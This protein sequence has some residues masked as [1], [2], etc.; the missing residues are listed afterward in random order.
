[1]SLLD[2]DNLIEIN[3]YYKYIPVGNS[4]KLIVMEE[5]RGREQAESTDK[6][7]SSKVEVMETRWDLLTWK[8]QNEV[9]ESASKKINPN[10]GEREFNFVV[11][12]DA[13]VKRCLKKWNLTVNGQPVPVTPE[14][15]DSLP[16]PVV[17]SLYSS[18]QKLL[19]YSEEDL[20][21]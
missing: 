5:E 12:R 15:I 17:L 16:G 11:Y 4:K 6:D 1:M 14:A 7:V 19:D 10:T 9:L 3:L 20:G 18:Y 8:E 2:K 21:N 13:I